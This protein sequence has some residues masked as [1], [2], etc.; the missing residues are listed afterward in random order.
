MIEQR[1]SKDISRIIAEW[2]ILLAEIFK[3]TLLDNKEY[4]A[5]YKE[6]FSNHE[7]NL[8]NLI[9]FHEKNGFNCQAYTDALIN[10]LTTLG[11]E[12]RK[13]TLFDYSNPK[14]IS[15]AIVLVEPYGYIEPQTGEVF[16]TKDAIIKKYAHALNVK[17]SNLTIYAPK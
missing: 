7:N 15:H 6:F 9:V 17:P 2:G 3:L 14:V 13:V 12:A 4:M 1:Q 5:S 8:R 10:I 16:T 11:I